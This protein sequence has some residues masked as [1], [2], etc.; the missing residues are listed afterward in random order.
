M[1]LSAFKN[2]N[3][4]SII[5]G[6]S[7]GADSVAMLR[8]YHSSGIRILAVHCNFHLRGKESDRDCDFVK[9]LCNKLGVKLKVVDF[10]VAEYTSRNKMSVEMACRELR[11]AEFRRLKAQRGADRIAVAHN[12]DD[13]VETF[14][15]NLMRGAGI[16]GLRGMLPDTGEIVRPLLEV[17]RKEILEYLESIGQN[18][19][20]DS[21]NLRSDFRRNYIRNVIIPQLEEEWPEAKKSVNRS[22]SNLRREENILQKE[23]QKILGKEINRL[24]YDEIRIFTEPKWLIYRFIK[25]YGGSYIQAEEIYR[26]ITD[27]EFISGRHWKVKR[28]TIRAERKALEFLP[29]KEEKILVD[30]CSYS[31]TNEI[32][33]IVKSAPLSELWTELD[34]D[35]IIFRHIRKGD[36][37]KP[38]GM[39]GSMPVS[40]ILKDAGL[41]E[42]EKRNV[43]IAEEKES[44]QIIW[45]SELKR[46][47]L[48]L[49]GNRAGVINRFRIKKT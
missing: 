30:C 26:S 21:T 19:V 48:Y 45:V 29:E 17:S 11:Y 28:G 40:K 1:D 46:S 38:L 37:I 18:Y 12:A 42:A 33:T 49:V 23:E 20:V 32:M 34:Y 14:F 15:L 16:A 5:A 36:R 41:S 6:V 44:H 27:P 2:V 9:A 25:K 10:D 39:T 24:G 31:N 47:R 13:N 43:I 4:Q 7:G 35:Q 8:A 22:I 3:I